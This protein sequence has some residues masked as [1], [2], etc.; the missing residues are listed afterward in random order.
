[1]R[2]EPLYT[3][4]GSPIRLGREIGRGGEGIVYEIEGRAEQVAKL[5]LLPVDSQKTAKLQTMVLKQTDALARLAAWPSDLVLK[6]PKGRVTGLL[7]RKITGFRPIHEL[8]TPK[9]RLQEFPRANWP[10]LVHVAANVARAFALVHSYGVVIGDVNHGNILVNDAGITALIDCD[11]YQ[12]L[13][14]GQKFIC[15][16]GV[17][18]YTPP[19]LQGKNLASV[20]RT[21]NHDNFGLALLIFHLLLMGRH[22]F[23]GRFLGAGEMPVERAIRE[24]RFAFSA[25]S[26]ALQMAPPPN[27]LQL[28]DLPL[29]IAKFF[30][31]AF[32]PA[33]AHAARPDA[34]QWMN[35]LENLSKE[36]AKCSRISSHHYYRQLVSCPWCRIEK[37]SAL[38]L[39]LQLDWPSVNS[40][41]NLS[42][43]WS[44]TTSIPAPGPEPALA[45]RDHRHKDGLKLFV[46]RKAASRRRKRLAIGLTIVALAISTAFILRLNADLSFYTTVAAV[47]AAII[48]AKARRS[49]TR[50]AETARVAAARYQGIQ[51]KWRQQASDKAFA[52]KLAELDVARKEFESLPRM[53]REGMKELEK[54]RSQIQLQ[55]F[56]D[57][58][59]IRDATLSGIGPGRRAMLA[60]YGIDTAA[61]VSWQSLEKVD[62]IGTRN[63]LTLVTW[64]DSLVSRFAF[65]PRL[66]IDRNEIAKLERQI[67]ER[68]SH[69]EQTLTSGPAELELIRQRILQART[70]LQK[71]N[72]Q[73][74][75]ALLQAEEDLK[76]VRRK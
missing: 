62:G 34:Q 72:D 19:E 38:T 11:S 36:L 12:V 17:A 6:A 61:D 63:A 28:S 42:A 33:A 10:F 40:N 44:Q 9:S 32:S 66:G 46:P 35:T 7:M 26:K 29:T 41:F 59:Y 18:A 48:V 20:L 57:S 70:S 45:T 39:F 68:R 54:N 65:N 14:N 51:E 43:V 15:E 3:S 69:L 5:Y 49:P 47:C 24:Y 58:Y 22:P 31:Q 55:K 8:Y 67:A 71:E 74:L 25:N 60:S 75:M 73:V 27:S 52:A 21:E 30:E 37:D 2:N 4:S 16:V 56:L 23:A 50:A 1:M 13:S 53:R 64:R 76:S